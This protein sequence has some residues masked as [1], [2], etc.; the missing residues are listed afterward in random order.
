[1]TAF[2]YINAIYSLLTYGVS[3]TIRRAAGK[4]DPVAVSIELT[5]MC[6][7]NCPNCATG[8][9]MLERPKGFMNIETA[10]KISEWIKNSS[11]SANLYF[12]GEPMLHPCF[13]EIIEIF[14]PLHGVISTNGHFLNAEN[15]K[16]L[17][18]SGLKKI[19]VSYDG[20]TQETYSAYR[21]G[22][23]LAGV[24][25]GILLLTAEL[26]KVKR[27]PSLELLFL[28]GRHN[29]HELND[30][31]RFAE[32]V[33][34]G[35]AVKSMQVLSMDDA[36]KWIPDEKRFSRYIQEGGRYRQK[37]GPSRGCVRTWTTAVVTWDGDIIPCCYDKDAGFRFGNICQQDATQIW[38]GKQRRDFLAG[39]LKSRQSWEICRCCSQGLKLFH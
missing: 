28:Y 33:N 26:K 6:N 34:A 20:V 4:P 5:N 32:S 2:G 18:I 10:A 24:T 25:E 3:I 12:Q 23:N 1:M 35:F 17:A 9:G 39:V 37:K 21:R 7:L 16:R 31:R 36:E 8:S 14:R 29:G 38:K 15:C 11:M 22:G 30:A 19:I 13:F 27:A